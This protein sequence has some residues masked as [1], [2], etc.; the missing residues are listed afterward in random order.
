MSEGE[1][2]VWSGGDAYE[3]Y[4]GRWSRLVARRFLDWL[5]VPAGASWLDVGC[6]TGE[7]TRTILET[8]SPGRV[9]G[10]DPSEPFLAYAREHVHDKRLKFDVG[11]AMNLP[12]EQGEFDAVVS[13]L[14]LN[15][16]TDAKRGASEMARIIKLGGTA[17][18]YVWDYAGKMEVIRRFFDAAI[19]VDPSATKVDE[20]PRFPVC[21][22]D[23][24]AELFR[25]AGL[26]DVQTGPI[27]IRAH[28][29]DFDDYWAPFL[30][31][32]GVAPAYLVSLP[33]GKQAA[34]RERLRET[35]PIEPDG[36]ITLI[37]RAWAVKGVT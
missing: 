20:G 19:D 16:M 34:V 37:A 13:G 4:I 5:A 21:N 17:A 33:E 36:S 29:R 35:L 1:D 30:A 18:A 14:V 15:F 10:I 27:D 28:F 9:F 7:L 11:D 22:P 24:L 32:T 2:T 3:A 31:G 26:R 25:S 23:A 8:Q 12:Y 6:G